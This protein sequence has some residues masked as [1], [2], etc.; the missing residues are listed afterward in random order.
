MPEEMPDKTRQLFLIFR[1][2]VQREREAQTIYQR[3][4]ELCPDA[5]LKELLQSFAKDEARHEK[6]LIQRYN[7]LRKKYSVQDE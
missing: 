7:H 2:A 1:D 3:A 6:V 5:K 4:A